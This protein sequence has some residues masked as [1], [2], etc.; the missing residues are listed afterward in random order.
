MKTRIYAAPAV[1][2]LSS[3]ILYSKEEFGMFLRELIS[4]QNLYIL[5]LSSKQSAYIFRMTLKW[6]AAKNFQAD[7]R[8]SG[9]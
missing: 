3:A 4:M 2:G 6:K 5:G 8:W 1:K 7:R 9:I